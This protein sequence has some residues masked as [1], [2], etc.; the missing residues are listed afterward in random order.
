MKNSLIILAIFL[1]LFSKMQAQDCSGFYPLVKGKSYELQNFSGKDKKTGR[2][3]FT[4]K[5]VSQTG[6]KTEAQMSSQVF[7]EKDKTISNSE[8]KVICEKDAIFVDM[9]SMMN[10]SQQ[11]QMYKDM[12]VKTEG[13]FLET[14]SKLQI[15]QKLPDGEMQMV[16][17]DKK[18]GASKFVI[19]LTNTNRTVEGKETVTVPAGTFECFKIKYQSTMQ[20]KMVEI[21]MNMPKFEFNVIE[22]V[23]PGKGIIKTETYNKNGK[24]IGYS[25]LSKN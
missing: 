4:V 11:N 12:D 15:G 13:K 2:N 14:P 8:Y 7:D 6:K 1:F 16:M 19:T 20:T 25:V 18:S 22:Y 3:V 23:A 10:N 21:S 5:E 24:L 9:R 17:A